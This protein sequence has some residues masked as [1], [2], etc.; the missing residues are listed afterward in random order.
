[1]ENK[2][3]TVSFFVNTFCII[4][5]IL[6]SPFIF[7][8]YAIFATILVVVGIFGSLI[9]M[10]IDIGFSVLHKEMPKSIESF[11]HRMNSKYDNF[12]YSMSFRNND[13]YINDDEEY[14]DRY[15]NSR[16]KEEEYYRKISGE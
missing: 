8:F 14:F 3:K 13:K 2:N 15:Y 12:F 10:S 6:V 11:Y 1:M 4:F 9:F 7:L 5:G 16:K